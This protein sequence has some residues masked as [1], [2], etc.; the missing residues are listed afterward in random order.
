MVTHKSETFNFIY[1]TYILQEHTLVVANIGNMDLET[2]SFNEMF[3]LSL[4]GSF[5]HCKSPT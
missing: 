5:I 3:H 4:S 2:F 1:M